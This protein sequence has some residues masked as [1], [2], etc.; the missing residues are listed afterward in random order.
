M[1]RELLREALAGLPY[2]LFRGN[3]PEVR[4]IAKVVQ[5]ELERAKRQ[6]DSLE[7]WEKRAMKR[8]LRVIKV[9]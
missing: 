1:G 9:S 7:L 5:E 2:R 8:V 3:L 4:T 6:P